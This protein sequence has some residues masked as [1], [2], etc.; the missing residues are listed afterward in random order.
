MSPPRA[1]VLLLDAD[2]VTSNFLVD[3]LELAGYEAML[4][5]EIARVPRVLTTT[6]VDVLLMCISEDT[7]RGLG[8]LTTIRSIWSRPILVLGADACPDDEVQALDKG[9]DEWISI[10]FRLKAFLAR[11]NALLRRTTPVG[12]EDYRI[13]ESEATITSRQREILQYILRVTREHGLPPTIS[14]VQQAFGFRSPNSVRTHIQALQAKGLLM[15]LPGI[16]RGLVLRNP[17]QFR[18]SSEIP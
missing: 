2:R 17:S 8:N 11:L 7:E 9:A 15:R 16:A 3:A 14:E 4:E 10:P 18:A 1:S 6:L 5:T 12:Q 13:L